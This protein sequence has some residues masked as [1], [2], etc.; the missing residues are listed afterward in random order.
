MGCTSES[1]YDLNINFRRKIH[2]ILFDLYKKYPEPTVIKILREIEIEDKILAPKL[3]NKIQELIK[4]MNE[5]KP[6]VIGEGDYCSNPCYEYNQNIIG[7]CPKCNGKAMAKIENETEKHEYD[8]YYGISRTGEKILPG[9]C[10][11]FTYGNLDKIDYDIKAFFE[12]FSKY[13]ENT[14]NYYMIIDGERFDA[15]KNLTL[16]E[17]FQINNTFFFGGGHEDFVFFMKIEIQN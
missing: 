12:Y 17:F 11:K 4:K 3:K 9:C 10:T 7:T 1:I 14:K 16:S 8:D 13:D 5:A 6:N 2:P 15:P